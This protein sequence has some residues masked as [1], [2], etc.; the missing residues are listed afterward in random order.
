MILCCVSLTHRKTFNSAPGLFLLQANSG[1]SWHTQNIQINKVIENEKCLFFFFYR[2]N[3]RDFLASPARLQFG[4]TAFSV[5]RGCELCP[6]LLCTV[7]A[8]VKTVTKANNVL[9]LYENSLAL[10]APRE[11]LRNLWGFCGPS[12]A[13]TEWD[14][15]GWV[16]RVRKEATQNQEE[17]SCLEKGKG[18]RNPKGDKRYDSYRVFDH[19]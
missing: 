17:T 8:N 16:C 10:W 4:S 11:Y 2:K 14:P 3:K 7:I 15:L 19:S 5:L 1:D 12:S 9:I 18:K 6:P 13:V